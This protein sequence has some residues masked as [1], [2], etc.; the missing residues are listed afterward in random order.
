MV[1]RDPVVAILSAEC[2]TASDSLTKLQYVLRTPDTPQIKELEARVETCQARLTEARKRALVNAVAALR[3]KDVA[4]VQERLN[5]I[6]LEIRI[7]KAII[8][9]LKVELD[10]VR[11]AASDSDRGSKANE[12]RQSLAPYQESLDRTM[13]EYLHLR[14]QLNGVT[15]NQG[16]NADTKLDTI[17][18]ELAA[19]RREVQELK[20]HK[21]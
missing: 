12:L 21:K 11:T 14:A 7:K 19:L 8:E 13:R 16:T 6:E 2:A 5:R 1:A 18:R 3:A 4:G 15:L 9:R 20:G 10:S 17:L